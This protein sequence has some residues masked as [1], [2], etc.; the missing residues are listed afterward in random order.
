ML[1]RLSEVYGWHA[2]QI[3][4]VLAFPQADVKTYVFMHSPEKFTV[5][6]NKKLRL[7]ENSPHPS[8]QD[9]VVKLIK[10]VYSL[11]DASKTWVDHISSGLIDYGFKRSQIDPCL[12]IKGNL[13]FCLYVDDAICL[14]PEKKDADKLIA[15]LERQGYVLTDEGPLSAYLGIQVD[16][17][18]GNRISMKQ[19]AFIERIIEQCHLKDLR[20]HD[21]PADTILKRDSEGQER[22][23]EFHYRSIIGQLN[24]LAATTRPDIQFAVHQCARFCES[25]KMSHEKAVKRIVRYLKR[26][27]DDENRQIQ[28]NR[29]LC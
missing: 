6:K 18:E 25:P 29:V 26:T 27:S 19:P 2:R 22:K 1:L 16:R 28:R 17:L 10:N 12:F 23:N 8:K 20:M 9:A 5:D 7:D 15:D 24:Y 3:D 11:K 13:L 14:A 21:T 4:F